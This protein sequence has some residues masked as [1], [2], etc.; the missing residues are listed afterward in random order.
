[1]MFGYPKLRCLLCNLREKTD[2]KVHS[3]TPDYRCVLYHE[4]TDTYTTNL[5]IPASPFKQIL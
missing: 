3:C 2:A 1:M 4:D 5:N